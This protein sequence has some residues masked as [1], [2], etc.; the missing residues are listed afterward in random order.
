MIDDDD[1]TIISTGWVPETVWY[2]S[3]GCYGAKTQA[4]GA[5]GGQKIAL[6]AVGSVRTF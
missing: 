5:Q 2:A 1:R 6:P 4:V 3:S